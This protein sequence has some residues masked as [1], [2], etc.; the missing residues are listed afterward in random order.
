MGCSERI[1]LKQEKKI[2]KTNSSFTA[3][4]ANFSEQQKRNM[5]LREICSRHAFANWMVM[6]FQLNYFKS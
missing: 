1:A 5:L 6:E 4:F 2:I 3:V